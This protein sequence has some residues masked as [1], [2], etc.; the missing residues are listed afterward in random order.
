[1]AKQAGWLYRGSS[2]VLAALLM[3]LLVA[4]A[5]FFGARQGWIAERKALDGSLQTVEERLTELRETGANLLVVA[6]RH[7]PESDPLIQELDAGVKALAGK[8]P[9]RT[10]YALGEQLGSTAKLLLT[11][12]GQQPT[13][14]ADE[15]DLG[16]V[17]GLLP[18][19]LEQAAADAWREEYN[20][21]AD[22]YNQGLSSSFSGRL[23]QLLGISPVDRLGRE[24]Q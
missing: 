13:V 17:Q 10:R 16:Y 8:T 12:L 21:R 6:R 5:L 4:G 14:Q 19:R 24:A 9:L 18:Q 20:A 2:L 3:I 15:R 22:I 23:A 11:Q 7:L 1:M